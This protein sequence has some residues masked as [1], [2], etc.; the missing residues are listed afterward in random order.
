[1]NWD[2][3]TKQIDRLAQ[4][5]GKN[6]YGEERVLLVW[7]EVKDLSDQW[8]E[9]VIDGF[10]GECRQAPLMTEFREQ[11]SKE[12]E[13]LWRIEKAKNAQD[14]KDFFAGTYQDEDKATIC[15]YIKKRLNGKVSD[16]DYETF[17]KHLTHAAERGS[18]VEK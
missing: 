17:I 1:M 18:H 15:Q 5:Y 12:R 2:K 7:K 9:K 16:E 10:I 3:F 14:A 8:I 6:A 11:I 13:R 4:T